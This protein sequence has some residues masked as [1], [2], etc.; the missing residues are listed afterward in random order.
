MCFDGQTYVAEASGDTAR[1]T[2]LMG[3]FSYSAEERSSIETPAARSPFRSI[4]AERRK[5]GEA[6]AT[7]GRTTHAGTV[8]PG[9]LRDLAG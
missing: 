5:L 7:G 1:V 6:E 2:T 4:L 9:C 3:W 8:S